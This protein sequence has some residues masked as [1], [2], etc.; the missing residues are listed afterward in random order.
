MESRVELRKQIRA[1]FQ[2]LIVKRAEMLAWYDRQLLKIFEPEDGTYI[3][4]S[5]V[6]DT[7]LLIKALTKLD[8]DFAEKELSF[9]K[10]YRGLLQKYSRKLQI[11]EQKEELEIA[12]A[13]LQN[14]IRLTISI[15]GE[16][17]K[18][19]LVQ[20]K[21]LGVSGKPIARM[22]YL[23]ELT[24]DKQIKIFDDIFNELT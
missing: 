22:E 8:N 4:V 5:A 20:A 18:E 24:L 3:K 23:S 19:K 7:T 6:V 1:E 13:M 14:R 21:E 11:A 9:Y 17:A 15:V 16:D 12:I 2:A 10:E